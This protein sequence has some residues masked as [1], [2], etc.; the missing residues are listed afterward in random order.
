MG[1]ICV[2]E[3]TAGRGVSQQLP[4]NDRLPQTGGRQCWERCFFHCHRHFVCAAVAKPHMPKTAGLAGYAG[5]PPSCSDPDPE[6]KGHK[7]DSV[8]QLS[9]RAT[10]NQPTFLHASQLA[11]S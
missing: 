2:C 8:P 11:V 10:A 9:F 7:R 6:E 5:L 4:S 1:N 3:A